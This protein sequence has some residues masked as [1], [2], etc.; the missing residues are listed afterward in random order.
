VSN[1][2]D[3]SSPK[4]PPGHANLPPEQRAAFLEKVCTGDDELRKELDALLASDDKAHSFLEQPAVE[5]AAQALI[6]KRDSILGQIIGHYKIISRIGAGGMGEVYLAKDT[7]LDRN[8]ALKILPS[9]LAADRN[10]MQRF[11]QEAK[12]ASALNHPNI[13]TIH[14]V[15]EADGQRFIATEFID[16]T[17]LR[18]RLSS[19]FEVEE[20][21]DIAIQI[22]SALAAAHKV[23]IVHRDIKPENVMI[24]RDDGWVKV[25]DF[26]L[27]KM[28][29]HRS[30]AQADS[31]VDTLLANTGPGVVM[32]TVA[33]MSPEQARGDK[34]DERTDIWSLG[35]VM[36]EM[37]A[38][39]SPFVAA[40]SNEII[41]A[42]LSRQPAPPLTRFAHNVPERL[43]EIVEKA[44]AKNSDE[45]Y[46]TSKDLLIDLK[47]LK[48]S[49]ELKAGIDRSASPESQL[50]ESQ[51]RE[52]AI[53]STA[54]PTSHPTSS[55][56]YIVNQVK[57]HKRLAI[58]ATALLLII[59]SGIV[60]AG[61][62]FYRSRQR[63]TAVGA[64]TISSIAILPFVNGNADPDS[65]F[66]SDGLTD[67]IIDR[68]SQLPG[69]RVMSHTA[70]FH[71]KGR[72][73]DPRTVG[74]EL[75]VEAVLTGRLMKRNDA[76][77]ISLELVN[78]KDNSHI[79]GGR[80][81]R[82]LS[83]LLALQKEIP[84]DVSEKLRLKLSGESKERLTRTHTDN[85][86]AYQL[87][88]KG[89]YSWEKWSQSGA[90][91][92]AG[93]FDEA[94]KKDPNYALAYS[95]LAAVYL[96]FGAGV[97]PDVPPKE[98]HRRAREA[99]IKA[100]SL[101][102][103]LGEAHAAMGQVL[104]YDNWDFTGAEREL[105]Q[106]IELSPS[107]AEGHHAYSHVLLLLGR[108][109]ESLAESKRLLELDPVSETAI[110]HL[111]YHY[112]YARQY[113]E[114]IQQL[115][116]AIQLYPNED[117]YDHTQ[118]GDV[119]YQKG[120]FDEAIEEYLKGFAGLGYPADKIRE[121]RRAFGK[122]GIRGFLEKLIEQDKAAPPAEL[123]RF[124]IAS[125][126]ARL[127]EK[128][129][130]FEWLEKAYAAHDDGLVR[131]KEELGFDNL[132][133]DPRFR[134]LLRRV[135]LPQ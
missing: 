122:S 106:A 99:A 32:G 28:T 23:H 4:R 95:G 61:V 112:L 130:A 47:R 90:K 59:A 93:Y 54:L 21:L 108:F 20:A 51:A 117:P 121:L 86:E 98:G 12:A 132:R 102:P 77:T 120:M 68:L 109:D 13:L 26:G 19:P 78:A 74:N 34:V 125:C 63:A 42:I 62:S 53:A 119:Y 39:C 100:L 31:A 111:G 110:G 70:V 16:G 9:A 129:Q 103:Q 11:V 88:L 58:A 118:L 52:T 72:D 44:L 65:E 15:S 38:G 115:R 82:K 18:E 96:N 8:V 114:A 50:A 17:T 48:Q 56:E 14:E 66:L 75:G 79:W 97:G 2:T 76:L 25:L 45:R 105:R 101:D 22:C 127:G 131:L 71:Y 107:Y 135:G 5:V 128:D 81:D 43:H 41:S 49:L 85:L 67:N 27:A 60:I 83:D 24:R 89:I 123:D 91:E 73:V 40:S 80:Y 29:Q 133:S 6:D 46:Q 113:D 1:K 37:I 36:Y 84:S 92:A 35:I 57:N 104:L 94:I 87:Y 69:L 10:R 134:D 30:N 55:A 124:D 3:T 33:Y 116:K 7:K 126:Y 64:P